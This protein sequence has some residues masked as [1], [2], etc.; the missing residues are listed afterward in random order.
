MWVEIWDLGKLHL[1]CKADL[2]CSVQSLLGFL[3]VLWGGY[4][5]VNP[6][7]IQIPFANLHN[8]LRNRFNGKGT[9]VL[10]RYSHWLVDLSM[11]L[12]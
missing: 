6:R 1:A 10:Y 3:I 9:A 8:T 4:A 12:Q 11:M 5:L 2:I 7:Q